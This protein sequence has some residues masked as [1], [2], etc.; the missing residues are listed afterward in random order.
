MVIDADLS[1]TSTSLRFQIPKLLSERSLSWQS[2]LALVCLGAFLLRVICLVELRHSPLFTVLIGDALQYDGW[3]RQIAGGQWIGTEVFYQTPLYP[4]FLAVI[5]KVAGRQLMVVRVIQAALGAASC[6][7]LAFAGRRFFSERVALVAAILLA[8]YP[9]AIFFDVIIQKSSLDLFLMTAVLAALAGF[10]QR[11]HWSWIFMA[12]VAIGLFMLNRENARVLVPIVIVWLDI[13]SHGRSLARRT[14]WAALFIAA[15]ML[16][17]LPVGLRNYFVGGEFLISTSQLGPNFYIGNHPGASGSYEPLVPGHG[18][19]IYERDDARQLAEAA[20]GQ[21]LSPSQVSQYWLNLSFHYIRSQPGDWLRLSA[22]KLLLTFS[23]REIVDTE[24]I[25]AYGHYSRL[26]RW[27]CWFSF[28]VV[29]PLAVFGG[30]LTRGSWRRLWLLYALMLAFCLAVAVFYV[31]ARYR[32]PMVPIVLLFSSAALCAIPNLRTRQTIA[33]LPGA[34][35]AIAVAISTNFLLPKFDDDTFL[36]IGQEL[37]RNGRSSEAIPVLQQAVNDTPDYAPARFNLGVAFNA[38][39]RKEEAIDQFGAAIN[40]RPDYFEAQAAMALTLLETDRSYGAVEH[41]RAAAGLRPDLATIHRDLGN[42]LIRAEQPAEAIAEYQR[43]LRIDRN[44]AS[45]HNSLA[46][47]LQQEG[48]IDEAI[49]HYEAALKI[50]PDDAGTHS[51][52]ALAFDARGNRA[53]AIEHFNRA[54]A[55]QPDNPGIRV[56]LAQ[57]YLRWGKLPEA[58]L[59]YEQ[60]RKL[61]KDSLELHLQ[62]A[63]AYSAAQRYDEAALSFEQALA[64]ARAAGA[65]EAATQIEQAIAVCR[66]RASSRSQP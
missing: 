61:D 59:Q 8:S 56:N 43:S 19:A 48:R 47:A 39:G 21:K 24:S 27:L 65:N 25:E 31:V 49:A 17:Q 33:W 29:F 16:V 5:F 50:K 55:L 18:N 51:N 35:L 12:G 30:W 60:A 7:L 53:A 46:V 36:N 6:G 58:I 41:F 10:Q 9:P 1:F 38:V 4:Y 11:M 34:L 42:A 45:T 40:L 66:S 2:S 23:G 26:L 37:V 44:D 63:E 22:R 32:Y 3:A 14:A 54:V 64:L 62:L 28:G 20:T 52:L 57:L 13:Y 15:V